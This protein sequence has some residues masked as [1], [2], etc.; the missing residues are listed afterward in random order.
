MRV[1]ED[2]AKFEGA[3][4]TAVREHFKN[5]VQR[6]ANEELDGPSGTSGMLFRGAGTTARYQ[7]CLHVDAKA[8]YSIIDKAS[9]TPK[10]T[11]ALDGHIVLINAKWRLPD[12]EECAYL[13]EEEGMEDPLDEGFEPLEVCRLEDVGWIKVRPTYLLPDFYPRIAA[14]WEKYYRRPPALV[15]R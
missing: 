4:K 9:R 12:E 6:A 10:K 7:F 8:L 11:A 3:S 15:P 14:L 1:H 2:P 13:L 5:W